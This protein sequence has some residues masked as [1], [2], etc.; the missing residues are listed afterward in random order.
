[1]TSADGRYAIAFNG[2]ISNYVELRREL[3]ALGHRF[4]T[5]TDTEVLLAAWAE[6]QAGCLPRLVGMFAFAIL[7]VQQRVLVLGRDP[8]GI[9]PLFVAHVAGG[10]AFA[11]EIE[12]L[13]ELPGVGREANADRVYDYLR[14]GLVDHDDATFF[15]DVSSFPRSHYAEVRLD[16]PDSFEPRAYWEIDL[17]TR[18][19]ISFDE[20]AERLRELFL[21][22]VRLHLRSDVP[23]GVFLSGGL[24]S[25]AI[26]SAVRQLRGLDADIPTFSYITDVPGLNEERWVDRASTHAGSRPHKVRMR[27]NEL[28]EYL[29]RVV[30]AQ[31]EPFPALRAVANYRLYELARE[32]GIKVVLVGQ[33]G[34]E[35]LG[36]YAIF[37]TARLASLVRQRRWLTAARYARAVARDT[38]G[39]SLSATLRAEGLLLPPLARRLALRLKLGEGL[40]PKWL[41]RSWLEEHGVVPAFKPQA[42]GKEALREKL[43]LSLTAESLPQ[44]LRRE[45]RNSMAFSIECRVP[46]L[47]P[48]LASFSLSLPESYLVASDGTRKAVFREAMRG[49]VPDELVD[50]RDKTGMAT[51][52]HRWLLDQPAWVETVLTS[53]AARSVRAL[54]LDRVLRE[55]ERVS[56]VGDDTRVSRWLNLI[57]WTERFQVSF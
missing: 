9:K 57:L 56:P 40:L 48:S 3:E 39:E 32:S 22:S 33:G 49:L 26:V 13:L 46:F 52:A 27:A 50:R 15:A 2:E 36:G 14:F 35:L 23:V 44:L 42:E 51:P 16:H 5:R 28:P 30:A 21:E 18:L 55:W 8:F 20:A 38:D 24:D 53:D 29:P 47:T 45:D 11:S 6:W 54:E 17:D 34:D 10:L 19:E 7:D 12:P 1:M 25:S 31:G 41:N 4:R 43:L 37:Q